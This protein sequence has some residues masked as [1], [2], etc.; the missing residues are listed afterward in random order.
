MA[1]LL[2]FDGLASLFGG[3][4]PAQRGEWREVRFF[5]RS[6]QREATYHAWVPPGYGASGGTYPALYLLHGVGG[7][8]ERSEWM[9]YGIAED[10]ERMLALGLIRPMIVILP[11][12]E[13]GYWMNHAN[14]GPRWGDFTA[15]DLVQHVDA[16]F[17]TD[18]VRTRRAIGGLSMGGHGALQLALNHPDVFAIA[19]AHSPTLRPFETSPDFF[20]DPAWYARN[21]PLSL[22]KGSAAPRRLATWIDVGHQDPWLPAAEALHRAYTAKKAGIEFH[23]LEGEHQ[24]WYWQTYLPE[25]L[26]FYSSALYAASTTPYGAPAAEVRPFDLTRLAA[27]AQ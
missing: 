22:V 2:T 16:T 27:N 12:A 23:V 20:G 24:G 7:D 4:F 5:S 25:Y 10:M 21:D 17:R 3:G 15:T 11:L 19:G 14:G 18:P 13:Q 6:L 26:N 1:R 9:G 8:P